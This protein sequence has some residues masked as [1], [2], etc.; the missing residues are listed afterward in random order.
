MMDLAGLRILPWGPFFLALYLA[1]S[2]IRKGSLSVSG[3]ITAFIVG[4]AMMAVPLRT[5]GGSLIVFYPIGSRVT[6]EGKTTK[7]ML[8]DGHQ[9]AGRRR[10]MQV[11]CNSLSAFVASMIWCAMFVPN[12]FAAYLL[13]SY[14][15]LR[16]PMDLDAWCPVSPGVADGWSRFLVY[17]AAG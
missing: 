13:S 4:F 8:E 5:F 14:V 16:T 2:G 10:A 17:A 1:S 9:E 15:A 12:S 3:G 7:A 6:K 11:I